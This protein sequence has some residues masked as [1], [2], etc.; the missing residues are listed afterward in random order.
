[1]EPR[2][3]RV[4]Y[5]FTFH[6]WSSIE[7]AGKSKEAIVTT[8]KGAGCNLFLMKGGEDFFKS[9]SGMLTPYNLDDFNGLLELPYCAIFRVAYQKKAQVFQARL[10]EP[11]DMRLETYKVK[12]FKGQSNELGRS[13]E[14]VK[15]KIVKEL[16]EM[17]HSILQ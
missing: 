4:R 2:K 5:N 9:L 1:K 6:D 8:M 16:K 11:A 7:K 10:L 14:I 13:G 17:A 15:Q 3:Y 12:S